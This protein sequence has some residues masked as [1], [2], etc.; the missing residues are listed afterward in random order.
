M[1]RTCRGC[2]GVLGIDCWHEA[3]CMSITAQMANQPVEDFNSALDFIKE[4]CDI[5]DDPHTRNHQETIGNAVMNAMGFYQNH[6]PPEKKTPI[7]YSDGSP[8]DDLPF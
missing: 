2:G 8:V 7:T 5:L 4:L 1:A 3:D 6:R